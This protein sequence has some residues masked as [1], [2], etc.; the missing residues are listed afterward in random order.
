MEQ[1]LAGASIIID[2][3]NQSFLLFLVLIVL[4]IF[5]KVYRLQ[6][7][8]KWDVSDI[9]SVFKQELEKMIVEGFLVGALI[10]ILHTIFKIDAIKV[11]NIDSYWKIILGAW[12]IIHLY[13]LNDYIR[14]LKT[15][16]YIRDIKAGKYSD[17]AESIFLS[18]IERLNVKIELQ[19]EVISIYKAFTPMAL[20]VLFLGRLMDGA[21]F[22]IYV[23]I[24]CLAILCYG[25]VVFLKFKELKNLMF[26]KYDYEMELKEF[27]AD[28]SGGKKRLPF[29][30]KDQEPFPRAMREPDI[31][32]HDK[33][34]MIEEPHGSMRETNSI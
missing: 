23:T 20:I 30:V 27:K 5:F 14:N 15:N 22:D 34:N 26:R 25:Y 16:R 24:F 10:W 31:K 32:I 17:D 21:E 6:T 11:L 9:L 19:K 28:K 7:Y 8:N 4:Y 3:F 2:Y 18:E 13:Q 29:I 33:L 1:F 12:I